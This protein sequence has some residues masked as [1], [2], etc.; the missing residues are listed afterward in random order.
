[1]NTKS[2]HVGSIILSDHL[3]TKVVEMTADTLIFQSIFIW[4]R[5]GCSFYNGT[6]Y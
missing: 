3:T 4:D 1:M 5:G 6:G 2:D